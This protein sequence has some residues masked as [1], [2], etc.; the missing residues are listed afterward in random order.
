MSNKCQADVKNAGT[1]V[2]IMSNDSE[3]F[4]R[5]SGWGWMFLAFPEFGSEWA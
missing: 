2:K 4:V 5:K 1:F 3:E